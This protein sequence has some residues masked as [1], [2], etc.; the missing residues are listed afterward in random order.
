MSFP[1]LQCL[2]EDV[3][4]FC[5]DLAHLYSHL[6]KPCLDVVLMT[7]QL[8]ML[9]QQRGGGQGHAQRPVMLATAVIVGTGYVLKLVTPPFGKLIAEQARRYGELRAAHSRVITHSEEIA[10]YG[11]HEIERNV[12]QQS[13]DELVSHRGRPHSPRRPRGSVLPA[14][15]NRCC[16]PIRLL[17]A[18]GARSDRSCSHKDGWWLAD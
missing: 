12:L 14:A 4:A 5:T 8:I 17:R 10:F 16:T 9:S 3:S 11:G 18:A 1:P 6:S 7:A 2:T 15:N 13:Y